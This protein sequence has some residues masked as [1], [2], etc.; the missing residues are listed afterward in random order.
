MNALIVLFLPIL[1][2]FTSCNRTDSMQM[3]KHIWKNPSSSKR[4]QQEQPISNLSDNPLLGNGSFLQ[5]LSQN[6]TSDKFALVPITMQQRGNN[7]GN[8]PRDRKRSKSDDSEDNGSGNIEIV[9]DNS[10]LRDFQIPVKPKLMNS[11]RELNAIPGNNSVMQEMYLSPLFKRVLERANGQNFGP[12]IGD[13]QSSR[14]GKNILSMSPQVVPPQLPSTS[15]SESKRVV[16]TNANADQISPMKMVQEELHYCVPENNCP[17]EQHLSQSDIDKSPDSRAPIPTPVPDQQSQ[18]AVP[19]N[20]RPV[21][22][23]LLVPTHQADSH[24]LSISN[25]LRKGLGNTNKNTDQITQL[26][27]IIHKH[28]QKHQNVANSNGN[29]EVVFDGAVTVVTTTTTTVV[30]SSS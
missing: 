1:L 16:N 8:G 25:I 27:E 12:P 15:H 30:H 10:G 18:Y 17:I 13:T 4:T 20:N 23:N 7:E 24:S 3:L 22:Q 11:N 28:H 21:E 5:Q 2:L 6:C 29:V 26:T 19:Q 14:K 9:Q